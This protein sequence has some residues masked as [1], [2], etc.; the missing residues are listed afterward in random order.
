MTAPHVTNEDLKTVLSRAQR[1]EWAFRG[2]LLLFIG[3]LTFMGKDVLAKLEKIPESFAAQL[4]IVKADLTAAVLKEQSDSD[5]HIKLT[6]W[7]VYHA[8]WEQRLAASE[9]KSLVLEN[10]LDTLADN[11]KRATEAIDQLN[12][13]V[14]G[15]QIDF[16]SYQHKK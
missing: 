2:L 11:Q 5:S 9:A 10:K 16:N 13:T 15:F 4:A 14:T 1:F 3:L 12:R 7:T 8:T 6:D